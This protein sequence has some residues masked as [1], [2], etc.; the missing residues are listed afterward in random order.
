M[1]EIKDVME[2]LEEIRTSYKKR[3]KV[4]SQDIQELHMG[5]RGL[6][7]CED[8]FM[9]LSNM[10]SQLQKLLYQYRDLLPKDE[11]NEPIFPES[12]LEIMGREFIYSKDNINR[13]RVNMDLVLHNLQKLFIRFR[14]SQSELVQTWIKKHA[15]IECLCDVD[16]AD[17]F[18]REI[19]CEE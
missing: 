13:I 6:G 17:A 1:V 15:Q 10:E 4:L 9:E 11:A 2:A 16:I 12:D 18:I 7:R 3:S 8:R 14:M 5:P 19:E